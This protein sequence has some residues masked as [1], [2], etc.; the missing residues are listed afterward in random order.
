M[1]V[2]NLSISGPRPYFGPRPF[3]LLY[4]QKDREYREE[5]EKKKKSLR[6]WPFRNMTLLVQRPP[7]SKFSI[8]YKDSCQNQ[9][10][11]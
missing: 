5:E 9:C 4:L 1:V 2:H 10:D 11:L 8:N 3:N 7:D 6:F